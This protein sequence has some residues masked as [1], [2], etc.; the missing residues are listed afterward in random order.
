MSRFSN[1]DYRNACIEFIDTAVTYSEMYFHS[2]RELE[3]LLRGH[4]AA[5]QQLKLISSD[6]SFHRHFSEWLLTTYQLSSAAGWAEAIESLA[7]SKQLEPQ[8]IFRNLVTEF[9]ES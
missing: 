5:F 4:E 1:A 3:L 8:V 7:E 6:D 2:L 9:F